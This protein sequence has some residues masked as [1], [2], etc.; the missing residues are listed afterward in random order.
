MSP[1]LPPQTQT[2]PPPAPVTNVVPDYPYPRTLMVGLFLFATQPGPQ[3]NLLTGSA[4]TDYETL[5]NLGKVK[6]LSPG[7]EASYPITRTGELHLEVFEIKGTGSQTAPVADDLYTALVTAGDALATQYQIRDVKFYLDDLLF[8]H[9]FPVAR[10]RFK[11][12]YGFEYFGMK[13]TIY[14]T[15]AAATGESTA[16]IFVPVLGL[17]PEYAISKNV[18]F[19]VSASG[20]GIPHRADLWESEAT[21]SWR[22]GHVETFVGAKVIHFKSSPKGT[23]YVVDTIDGAYAGVRWHL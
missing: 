12:I 13:V 9:K 8:P 6:R 23:E 14:D 21:L 19:R 10:L 7:I 2:I 1:S 11:A 4:A 5:D 15:P 16:N 22:I 18:L 20:F 3:P 17:A